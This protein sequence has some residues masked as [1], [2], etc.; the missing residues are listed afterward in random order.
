[1]QLSSRRSLAKCLLN[2]I[3][4][5][6]SFYI[7]LACGGFHESGFLS[8]LEE[9]FISLILWAPPPGRVP[10]LLMST[11]RT[12]MLMLHK[13]DLSLVS[14]VNSNPLSPYCILLLSK[15]CPR[16][17]FTSLLVR[18]FELSPRQFEIVR[19]CVY[20]KW[21]YGFASLYWF[22]SFIRKFELVS[23]LYFLGS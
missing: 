2:I 1:M 10:F 6:Q 8:C 23:E 20:Q 19:K 21:K 12:L 15:C 17:V 11:K 5:P 14:E 3:Q 7:T 22:K 4:V 16:G 9:S 18:K 13:T